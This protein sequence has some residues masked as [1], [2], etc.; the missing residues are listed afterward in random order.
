MSS[1]AGNGLERRWKRPG[2]IGGKEKPCGEED[3][4]K[5]LNITLFYCSAGNI[6][7]CKEE[8]L[9]LQGQFHHSNSIVPVGFG[10]KS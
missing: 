1:M 3:T 7:I 8:N 10:V 5:A 6:M 2:R 4:H 9:V